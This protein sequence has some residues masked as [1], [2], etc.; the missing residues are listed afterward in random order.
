MPSREYLDKLFEAEKEAKSL[1]EDARSEASRRVNAAKSETDAI[2]TE[3]RVART[4]AAELEAEANRKRI[5]LEFES[6]IEAFR[7]ALLKIP[8]DYQR[9]AVWCEESLDGII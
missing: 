6:E 5:D 9:F 4:S 8:S 2:E 7:V 3:S 1:I